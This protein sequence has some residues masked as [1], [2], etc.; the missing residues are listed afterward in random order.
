M[1]T[2]RFLLPLVLAMLT[3]GVDC[4]GPWEPDPRVAFIWQYSGSPNSDAGC[5]GCNWSINI[6][7]HESDS[8]EFPIKYFFSG[9]GSVFHEDRSTTPQTYLPI[10]LSKEYPRSEAAKP[11]LFRPPGIDE[12]PL[13]GVPIIFACE[14]LNPHTNKW[15]RS[16][17]S[18]HVMPR[19]K[20][21]D[22]YIMPSD[23][24]EANHNLL[25]GNG[26]Y[27]FGPHNSFSLVTIT[28]GE[29]YSRFGL[30]AKPRPA[31]DTQLEYR[32]IVP[33]GYW[34]SPGHLEEPIPYENSEG[35]FCTY[36]A[37]ENITSPMDI[38]ARFSIY[39]PWAKG[40][41]ELNLTFH[42]VPME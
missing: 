2:K 27:V 36:T 17:Y 20:P 10:D 32:L 9:P 40:R 15:E 34:G 4:P 37:P 11:K 7:F 18:V 19:D 21:M 12:V 6:I 25:D 30:N 14:A 33:D 24:D 31:E 16:E 38:V 5:F 35:W 8:A 22:Y 23:L 26:N 3:L 1:R 13:Y 41:R 39:D 42:V 29:T 28:A